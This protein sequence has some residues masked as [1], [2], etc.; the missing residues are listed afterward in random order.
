MLSLYHMTKTGANKNLQA[1]LTMLEKISHIIPDK[2]EF[3]RLLSLC[4]YPKEIASIARAL[5]KKD[6][7][8]LPKIIKKIE[9]TN[10]DKPGDLEYIR[11]RIIKDLNIADDVKLFELESLPLLRVK[12]FGN[13]EGG[14]RR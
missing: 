14:K 9:R 12:I 3:L 8:E 11:E 1:T 10:Y 2:P 7:T 13:F 4:Y 6:A 5:E